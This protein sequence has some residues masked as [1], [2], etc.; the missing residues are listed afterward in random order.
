MTELTV[1]MFILGLA[2]G[3]LAGTFLA[4]RLLAA[5]YRVVRRLRAQL[6]VELDAVRK[7]RVRLRGRG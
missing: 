6:L 2:L 5:E 4:Q 7:L 1:G 3:F